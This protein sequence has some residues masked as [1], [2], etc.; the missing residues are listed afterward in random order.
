MSLYTAKFGN[1]KKKNKT[2]NKV[3]KQYML[4]QYKVFKE[5]SRS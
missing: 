5:I 1:K 3:N 4:E 2:K